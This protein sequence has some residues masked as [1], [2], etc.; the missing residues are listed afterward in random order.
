MTTNSGMPTAVPYL[1]TTQSFPKEMPALQSVLSKRDTDIAQAINT[2]SIGIYNQLQTATGNKYYINTPAENT[3]PVQYRQ[4]FRQVFPF[5]AIAAG[6][7]ITINHGIS[8]ITQ[9]VSW[10]GSCVTDA[11]IITNAKYEP[12]PFTSTS[13]VNQQVMIYANDMIITIINGSGN[14]N[15]LNGTITLEYLLN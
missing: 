13:N 2:R 9:I 5:G 10:L 3:T 1:P 8:G 4:S 15:I 7:N 14:N 6:T 12:I 11:S